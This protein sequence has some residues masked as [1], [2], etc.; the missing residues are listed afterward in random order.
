MS[1][2]VRTSWTDL[3]DIDRDAA[4]RFIGDA[5]GLDM[6]GDGGELPLPVVANRRAAYYPTAFPGVG[7]VHLGVHQLDRGLDVA[8][9]ERAVAGP[10]ELLSVRHPPN[11]PGGD[12]TGGR[13]PKA[14]RHPAKLDAAGRPAGLAGPYSARISSPSGVSSTKWEA[15]P[16]R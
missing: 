3:V 16:S 7:P 12:E 10:Q 13:G 8:G 1:S 14:S 4:V 15:S 11:L 9:V 2:P 6:A 5:R